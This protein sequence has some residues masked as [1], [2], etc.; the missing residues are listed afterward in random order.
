MVRKW[1]GGM[2]RA[3]AVG[4][5]AAGG[6]W[7][8]PAHAGN[9]GPYRVIGYNFTD[10]SIYSFMIDGF[11]AG[12]STAHKRGGGGKS[13]CCM[14]VPRGKK[15][16]HLKIK[17]ELTQE[18]YR[19]GL[20]NEVYETD[21]AVPKLPNQRDGYIEFHF[22]PDRKIEA[23]WVEYPTD[24]HNPNATSNASPMTE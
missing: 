11:G 7:G 21:I 13:V 9:D 14:D 2:R 17:Y 22:L 15:T 1:P 20:P 12:G 3:V 10:R 19:N 23:K 8:A 5:V 4:V 16:W 24:P 6:L 18:Q